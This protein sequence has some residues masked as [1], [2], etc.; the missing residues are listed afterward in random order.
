MNL[1]YTNFKNKGQFV[2]A[3]FSCQSSLELLD[4][5]GLYKI[6]WCRKHEMNL[7]VDGSEVNLKKDQIIFCT[8]L[9][10]IDLNRSSEGIISFV[11]NKE[12][13]CIKA[14]DDQVSC[15]GLL[16]FGSSQ[17]QIISLKEKDKKIFNIIFE[18]FEEEFS[19]KDQIQGEMLRTL[20]KRILI[21]STKI[22]KEGK[23]DLNLPN[24]QIDIIRKYNILVEE[25]FHEWH[26]V[27]DYS[28]L[29]FKS[30]KTLTNLLKN[31][32]EISPLMVINKRIFLEA[33]RLLL[34]SDK[35]YE[36]IANCLGYK[37][38]AHFLNFLKGMK[39]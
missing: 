8:P 11:F 19:V 36:E 38:R 6:I 1:E 3:D 13:F 27:K 2:L 37:N 18:L 39:S 31:Y 21:L 26:Q 33:K 24:A 22:I 28:D 10:I 30:P 17:P 5:K 23:F 15:N 20:L 29:L 25:H 4:Q 14:H 7:E 12:F 32:G 34:Y 16:F 9:N 35:T